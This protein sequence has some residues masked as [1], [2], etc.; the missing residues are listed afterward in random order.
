LKVV[1]E[2]SGVL[3]AP[4]QF[5]VYAV[6]FSVAVG[7]AVNV[8]VVETGIV[9]APD[10]DGAAVGENV[11]TETPETV[12]LVRSRR[13]CQGTALASSLR[14]FVS[15]APIDGTGEMVGAE[16]GATV[17]KLQELP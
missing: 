17:V 2:T 8:G 5:F 12:T 7:A 3:K 14:K 1:S 9:G 10:R 15:S 11:F 13:R 16:D 6:G 4:H